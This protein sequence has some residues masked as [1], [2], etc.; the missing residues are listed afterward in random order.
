MKRLRRLLLILFLLLLLGCAGSYVLIVAPPPVA[1]PI[2][3]PVAAGGSWSAGAAM[4][5]GRS[6][7]VAATLD[8]KIYVA[9][10]LRLTG[11]TAA[12]EVYDP[13]ADAWQK[14]APLPRP[15]HHFGLA[16]TG[17]RIYVAGGYQGNNLDT[18]SGDA[19]VYDPAQDIWTAIAAMPGRR[20][21]HTLV[22]LN[23]QLY[24][25]GGVG[26]E[27]ETIWVYDPAGGHWQQAPGQLPTP[28]EH[29]AAAVSGDRIVVIGGRWSGNLATVDS[30]DPASGSWAS[31]P[32]MPTARGGLTAATLDGRIHVTGGENFSRRPNCTFAQHE[33]FDPTTNTWQATAPLPTS[34]HGLASAVV[35]GRLYVVGGG[36]KPAALTLVSTSRRVEI[37]TP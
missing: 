28:R 30:Y 4:P 14:L 26:D 25:V 7:L 3:S 37:F 11:A 13:V 16:A 34:R 20:A 12:F 5:T 8:G 36:T 9:G 15:L 17:Q 2:E 21:A 19:W 31:H 24:V 29:L 18:P 10:G 23:E 35:D 27:V 32:D 1:C 33:V 6:E 22:A